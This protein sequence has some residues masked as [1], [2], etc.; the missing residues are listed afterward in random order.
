MVQFD[1]DKQN[2]RVDD[3]HKE[4]EENLTQAMAKQY[5]LPYLD[6]SVTPINI[7]A[8]RFISEAEAREGQIAVF[9]DVDKKLDVAILSPHNALGNG[10]IEKLK[11]KGFWS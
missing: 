11:E 6:L 1:E 8:L 7:D 9:N 4:E 3:L 2:K 5:G 10:T